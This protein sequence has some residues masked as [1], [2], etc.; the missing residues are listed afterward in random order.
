MASQLYCT[1]S[2]TRKEFAL[3]SCLPYQ[4]R[5]S[6]SGVVSYLCLKDQVL[7]DSAMLTREGTRKSKKKKCDHRDSPRCAL[8]YYRAL[9]NAGIDNSIFDRWDMI[10]WC[11]K[12]N[13]KVCPLA[14]SAYVHESFDTIQF[15][16]DNKKQMPITRINENFVVKDKKKPLCLWAL[17]EYANKAM[18]KDMLLFIIRHGD[19]CERDETG[20]SSLIQYATYGG[21]N[22][23]AR[24]LLQSDPELVH[25]KSKAGD[26][27]LIT[28]VIFGQLEIVLTIMA[29]CNDFLGQ[30]KEKIMDQRGFSGSTAVIFAAQYGRTKMVRELLKC[31]ADVKI[32]DDDSRDARSSARSRGHNNI[33]QLIDEHLLILKQNTR[34]TNL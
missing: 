22:D 23:I 27:A 28:A 21:E 26:T 20:M 25:V 24:A 13:I 2:R 4:V 34:H 33:V 29:Y 7:L 12:K 10:L 16:Y 9:G 19:V 14:L 15:L 5:F 11:S 1:H 32:K 3:W 8:A 6:P 30:E 18:D 31:G 17:N